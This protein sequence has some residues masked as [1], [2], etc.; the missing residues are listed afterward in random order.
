MSSFSVAGVVRNPAYAQVADQIRTAVL[1]GDLPA[2]SLLPTERDLVERF[3]VSRTTVR[4]ALRVLQTQGIIVESGPNA[5]LRI[6][7]PEDLPGSAAHETLMNLIHLGKISLGD[8]VEF[9]CVIE[10]AAVRALASS[11]VTRDL[12]SAHAA[13][14]TMRAAGSDARAFEAADVQLHLAL[15]EATGNQAFRLVMLAVRDSIGT[16]LLDALLVR[17]DLPAILEQLRREHEAIVAAIEDGDGA[18]ASAL[19]TK[20]ISGFYASTSDDSS[21]PRLGGSE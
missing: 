14:E 13:L 16:Y 17:D 12:S 21:A 8:L 7:G 19:V 11:V 3:G 5:P 18:R 2:G 6:S 1:R 15:V 10:A 4:E 9:R 20:H